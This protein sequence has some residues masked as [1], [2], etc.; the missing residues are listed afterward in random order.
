MIVG[1]GRIMTKIS[2]SK[3]GKRK[4]K[5]L[6]S[7][8]RT[9]FWNKKF[10]K[11]AVSHAGTAKIIVVGEPTE[12]SLYISIND[13]QV[14]APPMIALVGIDVRE[15]DIADVIEIL[16]HH[17]SERKPGA[18]STLMLRLLNGDAS[19]SATEAWFRHLV[20]GAGRE[21]LHALIDEETSLNRLGL[22]PAGIGRRGSIALAGH[23][24]HVVV[25]AQGFA[26]S[27][28]DDRGRSILAEVRRR[29]LRPVSNRGDQ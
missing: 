12:P 13:G 10:H 9:P 5:K 25:P 3:P 29:D 17:L 14:A 7:V 2:G 11:D 20:E 23:G 22:F 8:P 18:P 27:S 6:P 21:V 28:L 19:D 4:K 15:T 24:E 16:T 1:G 26:M